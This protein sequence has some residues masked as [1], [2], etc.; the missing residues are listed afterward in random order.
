MQIKLKIAKFLVVLGFMLSIA[1]YGIGV[2]N[3][4]TC[5]DD[6]VAIVFD[7]TENS[8]KEEKENSEKEE[9]KEKDKISLDFY[10]KQTSVV[11]YITS[12]YPDFYLE[13]IL[14]YLEENTPP[15]EFS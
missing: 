13:N 10:E 6:V 2:I 5:S 11:D 12:V 15:P 14:I 8:E 1:N 7:E 4:Y 3:F 9:F